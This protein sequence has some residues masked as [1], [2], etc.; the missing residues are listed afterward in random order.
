M[1]RNPRGRKTSMAFISM[2][3]LSMLVQVYTTLLHLFCYWADDKLRALID[4]NLAC[5][6]VLVQVS[7]NGGAMETRVKVTTFSI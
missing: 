7:L 4:C 2:S 5:A 3:R 1:L 6:L